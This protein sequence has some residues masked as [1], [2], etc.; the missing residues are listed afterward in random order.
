MWFCLYHSILWE[1]TDTHTHYLYIYVCVYVCV[2]IYMY[3]CYIYCSQ[4]EELC[5]LLEYFN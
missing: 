2:C 3:V 1:F 4:T 5:K